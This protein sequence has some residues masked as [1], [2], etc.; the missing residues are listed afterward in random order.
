MRAVAAP[1]AFPDKGETASYTHG[2]RLYA[3]YGI[4]GVRREAAEG[5]PV[6]FGVALPRLYE[7][8]SLETLRETV[9]KAEI[10]EAEAVGIPAALQNAGALTL[11]SVIAAT[12]DTCLISRTSPERARALRK[13]CQELAKRSASLSEATLSALFALDDDFIREG[14]SPGGSAD[15]LAMTYFL[16][17]L[18]LTKSEKFPMINTLWQAEN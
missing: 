6:L 5:F 15:I 16:Y 2:E 17:F 13:R 8:L 11:L 3:A 18:D 9:P 1:A 7:L 4:G 12:E 10:K 14:A